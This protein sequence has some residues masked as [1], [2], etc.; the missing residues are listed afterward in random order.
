MLYTIENFVTPD[1]SVSAVV[2]LA[3]ENEIVDL[4]VLPASDKMLAP[5]SLRYIP[6]AN[7]DGSFGDETET[8]SITGASFAM[9]PHDIKLIA[10]FIPGDYDENGL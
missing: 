8:V 6:D 2:A 7:D 4:A 10:E 5:G 1:G 9:P 3:E